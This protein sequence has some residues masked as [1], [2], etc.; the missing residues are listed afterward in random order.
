[1]TSEVPEFHTQPSTP[2]SPIPYHPP[3]PSKLPVLEKQI[4]PIFNMTST[5]TGGGAGKAVALASNSDHKDSDDSGSSS[6]ANSFSDPFEESDIPQSQAAPV[7]TI[8]PD[9]DDDYAM[10][11]DSDGEGEGTTSDTKSDN[12]TASAAAASHISQEPPKAASTASAT[13]TNT[14]EQGHTSSKAQAEARQMD[15]PIPAAS[16]SLQAHAQSQ[17]YRPSTPPPIYQ[18]IQKGEIDIQ[19][20][21]DN[22]TANAELEAAK[23]APNG[24]IATSSTFPPGSSAFPHTSLPPRPQALSNPPLNPAYAA[25]NDIRNYHAGPAYP[26]PP[27][28]AQ[29]PPGMPGSLTASGA[30]GT[31]TDPRNGLPP[32]PA[33]SFSPPNSF[34]R[35]N[36][37]MSHG[38]QR[39]GQHSR[40]PSSVGDVEDEG[41][42]QWSPEVQRRYE[43]FLAEE[44]R[45]VA[46]GVW[47]R[48]PMG[49]RLFIGSP[50][51]P[52]PPPTPFLHLH[53]NND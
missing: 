25:Q 41:E 8:Q 34:S 5:H 40:G 29:R 37:N 20:L 48:F 22:I 36:Q 43:E 39:V 49:S 15:A 42:I 16:S 7:T 11:F 28:T 3:V 32:P 23:T 35:P 17:G 51:P 30:P 1:M 47:D 19:Q 44:R 24:A 21:L 38:L 31:H 45:N 50:D 18:S 10:T 52:P 12:G 33:A 26:A 13:T 14:V 2:I 46:E 27:G 53:T 4:D 6:D 9:A